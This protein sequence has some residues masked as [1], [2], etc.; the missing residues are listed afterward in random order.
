V[1]GAAALASADPASYPPAAQVA[2]LDTTLTPWAWR[3]ARA[4]K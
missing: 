2:M 1:E 3:E 4:A